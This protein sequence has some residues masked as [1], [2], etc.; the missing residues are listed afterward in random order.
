MRYY[1]SVSPG[2][3]H[4]VTVTTKS[5]GALEVTLDDVPY[6]VDVIEAEP[7][8]LV[9]VNERVFDLWLDA[10]HA[11]GSAGNHG[12][13]T[14]VAGTERGRAV[15]ESERARIGARASRSG[16]LSGGVIAAPMPGRVVKLLV[17]VGDV[18][19]AGAPIVVVE[20]MKMENELSAPAAGIV[21]KILVAAGVT[22]EA[23]ATLVELG[24]VP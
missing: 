14:F 10:G 9:R 13:V 8:L 21:Q 12:S 5:D 20:A 18:V 23:G 3:E 11:K 19:D 2:H 6:A 1:V 4:T 15:L 7:A 22:V 17:E 24:A 16:G